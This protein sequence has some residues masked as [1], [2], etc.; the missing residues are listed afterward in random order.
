MGFVT[1][2]RIAGVRAIVLSNCRVDVLLHDTY[3][4]ISHFHQVLSLGST[5]AIF[6][7]LRLF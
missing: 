6:I 1:L 4:T 2:F 5:F 7:S 3:F